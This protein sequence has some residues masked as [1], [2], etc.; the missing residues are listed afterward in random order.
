MKAFLWSNTLERRY[1]DDDVGNA[2]R[3]VCEIYVGSMMKFIQSDIANT[4]MID[5]GSPLCP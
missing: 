4:P 3:E 2:H 5:D 1:S